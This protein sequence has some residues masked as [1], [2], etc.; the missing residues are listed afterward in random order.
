MRILIFC[1]LALTVASCKT[2]KIISEVDAYTTEIEHHRAEYKQDFIKDERSPLREADFEFMNFYPADINYKC[3]CS[4]EYT[5]DA[6][7]FEMST[8]SGKT[9]IFTKYGVASCNLDKVPFL[10]NIYGSK[11]TQA[12]PGYRDY[13]FIPYKDLTSGESTYGGGRYIDMRMG[14]IRNG[15]VTIDFNKCYNPWCMYSDGYNCPIPPIENHFGVEIKAGEMVW[16]GE[17]KKG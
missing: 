14:D 15:R 10:V 16:T 4:F 1:L 17:K 6:K 3:D 11:Q 8:V 5:R 2:K 7:P 9:K 12:M 13:L